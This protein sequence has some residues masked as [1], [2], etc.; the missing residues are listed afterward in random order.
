[1]SDQKIPQKM[2]KRANLREEDK[3]KCEDYYSEVK[4]FVVK[5]IA[6]MERKSE[7]LI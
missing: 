3:E 4:N 5:N 2:K 1:M 7:E 6:A